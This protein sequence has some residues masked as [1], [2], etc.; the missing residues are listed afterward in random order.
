[1]V[2]IE[3]LMLVCGAIFMSATLG[4]DQQKTL[5]L[6]GLGG[7]V[8]TT[9]VVLAA[10]STVV[11]Y[12]G[13]S[14]AST[15]DVMLS[16]LLRDAPKKWLRKCAIGAVSVSFFCGISAWYF[17]RMLVPH[18][19][20]SV[21]QMRGTVQGLQPEG[22]GI[23]ICTVYMDVALDKGETINVCYETGRFSPHRLSDQ[24]LVIGDYV[25]LAV[26]HTMFGAAIQSINRTNLPSG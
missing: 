25:E 23:A 3:F 16:N 5:Y 4:A 22:A 10:I 11:A 18:L 20:G 19:P 2:F 15:G 21:E 12:A 1:M 6:T 9:I 8:V 13:D 26:S 7:I 17:L 14:R 24:R